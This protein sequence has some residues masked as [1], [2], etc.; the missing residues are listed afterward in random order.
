MEQLKLYWSK[1]ALKTFQNQCV[2]YENNASHQYTKT[3]SINIQKAVQQILSMPS[4]GRLE[5]ITEKRIY[6]SILSHPKS[7][8]HYWYDSK[9][10]H[11]VGITFS[12]KVY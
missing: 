10:L 7:R 12:Q 3:F 9:Q 4:M 5:K 8:I 1:L 2:W 11:I 6:R